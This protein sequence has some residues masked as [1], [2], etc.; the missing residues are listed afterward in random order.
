MAGYEGERLMGGVCGASRGRR[1]G[2]EE[3][4]KAIES[5]GEGSRCRVA[6]VEQALE[7]EEGARCMLTMLGL[8][9]RCPEIRPE[10]GWRE[11]RCRAALRR[12]RRKAAGITCQGERSEQGRGRSMGEDSRRHRRAHRGSLG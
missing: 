4:R 9:W 8:G 10:H 1:A 7:G 12:L 11:R 3:I 6:R 5:L 2:T